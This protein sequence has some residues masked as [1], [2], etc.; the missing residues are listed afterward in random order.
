MARNPSA[1]KSLEG[2]FQGVTPADALYAGVGLASSTMLPGLLIKTVDTSAKKFG[3][4]VLAFGAAGVAGL[5]VNSVGG[6]NSARAAVIGGVAGA[7][8]Q[9]LAAY[10]GVAIGRAPIRALPMGRVRGPVSMGMSEDSSIIT[11][12]T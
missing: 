10:T 5:A 12:V 4:I 3:K 9:A 6:K 11:N 2:F 1:T 7:L 8:T